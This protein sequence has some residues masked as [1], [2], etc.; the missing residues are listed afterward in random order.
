[1]PEVAGEAALLVDPNDTTALAQALILLDGNAQLRASL[2][3][4]G[5]LQRKQYSWDRTAAIVY[6]NLAQLF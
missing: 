4:R 2:V 5:R 3:E 1:M 6:E